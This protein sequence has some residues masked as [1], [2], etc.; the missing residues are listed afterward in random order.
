MKIRTWISAAP[1]VLLVASAGL[2][3]AEVKTSASI[4]AYSDYRLRG[5]SLS[6]KTAVMQGSIE[7]SVPLSD[8][9]S[10]FAG[11]WGS[12]LDKEAGAGALEADLYGGVAV[13]TGDLSW[14]ATYLRIVFPDDSPADIDFDQYAASVSFPLGP[15][16]GTVGVVHDEYNGGT[17][18]TYVYGSGSYTVPDT[19]LSLKA[20]LGYED[21]DPFDG[22]WNWGLGVGYTY[23]AVTFGLEYIDTDTQTIAATVK[24]L[25]DSTVVV[26]LTSSF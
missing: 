5:M 6:D 10:I 12:S 20:T 26:S 16:G 7:A 1:A 15:V 2:A 14:K 22:K 19:P 4:G 25:T 23:K 11:L 21:G 17:Q 8:N 3:H 18:S 13:T 24:D 9:V